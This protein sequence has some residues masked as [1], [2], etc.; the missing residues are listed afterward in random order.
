V[1]LFSPHSTP[2]APRSSLARPLARY[3]PKERLLDIIR[4]QSGA[5]GNATR[6][7]VRATS[8]LQ[9]YPSLQ[10]RLRLLQLDRGSGGF[11]GRLEMDN[12]L[13]TLRFSRCLYEDIFEEEEKLELLAAVCCA[14]DTFWLTG[15][16]K[17]KAGLR[18]G[19][20]ASGG[21]DCLFY[22]INRRR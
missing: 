9:T 8:F 5:S 11:D 19:S 16:R 20:K 17:Y 18:D 22:V 7:L 14:A 10:T 1:A 13:S 15:Q 3:I 12:H 21:K 2:H 6:F 4:E